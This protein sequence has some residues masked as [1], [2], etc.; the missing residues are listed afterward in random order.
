MPELVY[1]DQNVLSDLRQRKLREGGSEQAARLNELLKDRG[2]L[3]LVY[4]Y[5]HLNEIRQISKD[6][7]IL[8]HIEL[9]EAMDSL[10]IEPR[11]GSLADVPASSIWKAYQETQAENRE[12]GIDAMVGGVDQFQR[13]L[14]GLPI[15]Q[16]FSEINNGL[17]ESMIRLLETARCKIKELLVERDPCSEEA[18][19]LK[20][21]LAQAEALE[22]GSASLVPFTLEPPPASLQ[23][24]RGLE[25]LKL[26]R[27]DEAEPE[28]VLPKISRLFSA[29]EGS[30]GF[31]L[32]GA[33]RWEGI[34]HCYAML[35]WAGYHADDFLNTRKGRDRFNASGNDLSHAQQASCADYLVS[36]DK[37]F[38]F[39]V[40]AS[41]SFL[42]IPT[43]C[44]DPE[45]FLA[46]FGDPPQSFRLKAGGGEAVP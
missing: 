43:R 42:G 37:A 44:L 10:Y 14:A 7:F 21:L 16:S 35:N 23:S 46:A 41:Y 15:E 4:S 5:T 25:E 28:D 2:K 33:G 11:G 26:L 31:D 30:S 45:E 24:F 29:Q 20:E 9:L 36:S 17:G 3:R 12:S 40:K 38:L 27:L 6:E 19:K 39:K 1:L 32:K 22:R 13:K 34:A 18:A 8:E